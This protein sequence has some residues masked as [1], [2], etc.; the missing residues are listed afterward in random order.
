[1][2]VDEV[3]DIFAQDKD[4]LAEILKIV[5]AK[6]P[7]ILTCSATMKK[8]FI[9]YY[10]DICKDCIKFNINEMV[11][12]ELGEKIVTL[13]GVKNYYKIIEEKAEMHKYIIKTIFKHLYEK[14]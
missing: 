11:Q 1:M 7:N 10:E 9:A 2:A 14:T 13:E 3:D 5:E 8:E 6:R 4:T 12:K